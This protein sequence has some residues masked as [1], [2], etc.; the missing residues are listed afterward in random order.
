MLEKLLWGHTIFGHAVIMNGNNTILVEH[1]CK[2]TVT[3]YE[4]VN[5]DV[6]P[7]LSTAAQAQILLSKPMLYNC[8]S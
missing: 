8:P 5:I 2:A 1:D 4:N 7:G 6:A 3:E